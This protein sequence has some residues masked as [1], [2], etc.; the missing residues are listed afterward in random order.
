[1]S[2]NGRDALEGVELALAQRAQSIVSLGFNVAIAPYDDRAIPDIGLE[3]ARQ[4]VRDSSILCVVGH[5]N[6]GVAIPASD[7]YHKAGLAMV[8]PTA[9]NFLLTERGYAEINRII[10]RDDHQGFAAAQYAHSQGI[11][12]V[13]IVYQFRENI[14]T[15]FKKGAEVFNINIL[16]FEMLEPD[17]ASVLVEQIALL[18]PDAVYLESNYDQAA[19]FFKLLREKGYM[20]LLM[21]PDSLDHPDLLLAGPALKSGRGTVYTVVGDIYNV[22]AS[23]PA[24]Q[25]FNQDFQAY[26]GHPP[27]TIFYAIKGYDAMS[28]CLKGIEDT[29]RQKGHILKREDVAASIRALQDFPGISYPAIDFASNGDLS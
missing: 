1:M 16:G 4:I 17:Q 3:N 14:A 2:E 8:S 10:G 5:L 23:F 13:F 28:I 24:V 20:G 7:E 25:Q 6:S 11:Q 27:K 15:S 18:N 22:R 21:G 29:I 19:P 12:S 26:F 9:T